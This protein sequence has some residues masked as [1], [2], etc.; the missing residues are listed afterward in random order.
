M[1]DILDATGLTVK[2]FTELVTGLTTG[3]QGIY[4][5]DI[6][7]DQNSPDGQEIG[8]F[9]QAG[10]DVRELIVDT[11]NSFDPDRAVGTVLDERVAINNIQREGGTFTIQPIDIT[12]N[13]TITL[14]G[15][16]ADFNNVNG[17]GYTVQDNAGNQFI[18]E[19]TV[20]LTA[21]TSTQ[22]FRAAKIGV[23]TPI[24]NTITNPVTI[25]IPVTAINNPAAALFIGQNQETDAQL[26]V[27]RSKSVALGST[28]YLNGLL[29]AILNLPGVVDAVLYQN[30]TSITDVNG[31]PGH[32]IWLVVDGGS[33][34]DIGNTIYDKISG[35][36]N[37]R[38]DQSLTI[39]Q[40][41]GNT[42]TVRWDNPV[43]EDLYI[44]FNIQ[45]TVSTATFDTV[46]IQNYIVANLS[47]DIGAFAETSSITAVALAA[48]NAQGGQGVPVDVK[49]SD[50]GSTWVDFLEPSTIDKQFT[51]AANR[52]DITVL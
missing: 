3:L 39:T 16:D 26:R 23:V 47:Y 14:A 41:S 8:I 40:E 15:L 45:K 38:G 28:G 2:T 9:S 18:L 49:V 51:L 13:A 36:C 24:V 43:A 4:G 6:N 44:E 5:A 19:N 22:N 7:V 30:V 32:C 37:M 46:A 33:S 52:I 34:S 48:I 1:P 35:G 21:G 10:V 50:D 27:R 29:G 12:V 17:T 42:L 25:V 11:Y 20:T 31:I